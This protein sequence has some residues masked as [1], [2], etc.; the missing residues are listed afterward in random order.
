MKHAFMVG[1][2][3][4]EEVSRILI[5]YCN[6]DEFN[7]SI[8]NRNTIP[9]YGY[10]DFNTNRKNA[11]FNPCLD[12]ETNLI[13]LHMLSTLGF[14][15]NVL[16]SIL[17]NR[18]PWLL[19]TM[20]ITA[21]N[22][23]LGVKKVIQHLIHNNPRNLNLLNIDG[24]LGENA[25]VFS[26]PFRNCMMHYDLVDKEDYPVISQNLYNSEKPLYGLVE[27]CFDGMDFNHYFD[28]LYKTSLKLEDYLL[29]YFTINY[30]KI[31]WDWD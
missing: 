13:L 23:V 17:G 12:K 28:E 10:I 8:I 9:E 15:N 20:Y 18:E 11:F 27:S 21:H 19:R 7:H 29:S 30:S 22:T 25:K 26:T 1:K 4:G 31:C 16:V 6:V 3:L 2:N 5:Q 14:T 24:Y